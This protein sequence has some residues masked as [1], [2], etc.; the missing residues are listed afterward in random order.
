MSLSAPTKPVWIVAVVLGAVGI[1]SHFVAIP[2][3]TENQFWVVAIGFL[4]LAVA[5]AMKG[6]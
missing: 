1:A 6:I 3:V 4:I 2:G 5:T